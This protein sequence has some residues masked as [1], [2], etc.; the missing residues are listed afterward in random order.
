MHA[1]V[2]LLQHFINVLLKIFHSNDKMLKPTLNSKP[3]WVFG[4]DFQF[5]IPG[6]KENIISEKDIGKNRVFK[7]KSCT[8][9]E[10]PKSQFYNV[11]CKDT[12]SIMKT[13]LQCNAPVRGNK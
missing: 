1:L 8:F 5:H 4:I 11:Y 9:L 12:A 3:M 6:S 13:F 2:F 10:F 7:Q